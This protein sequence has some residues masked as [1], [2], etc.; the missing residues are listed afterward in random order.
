M[1]NSNLTVDVVENATDFAAMR[2]EWTE[3]LGASHSDCL[4]LTWEWLHTWWTHFGKHRRLFL[5][6]V[7][8]GS[9]LVAIAPLTSRR[10][11]VGPLAVPILEFA[12]TGTIGS[13][14]L[15]VIVRRTCETEALATLTAFLFEKA[16]TLRLPRISKSSGLATSLGNALAGRGWECATVPTEV[17]PFI[18]LSSRSWDDYLRSIGPSHRYNFKR[19][20]RNLMRDYDVR[21]QYAQSDEERR[22]G[23]RH[24]VNLHLQR[25]NPRGGSDA[26]DSAGLV[27][28]H[29]DL[30]RAARDRGWLRLMVI[31][32]DGQAAAAFY[33]F[34]YGDK[35]LFYQSGFDPAFGHSSVGLVMVGL[36][37]RDAIAEGATEYDML[38]GVEPYKFLWTKTVRQLVRLDLYPPGHVGRM[39]SNAARVTAGAK[40][41]AKRLL[42]AEPATPPLAEIQ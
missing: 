10:I 36:T 3:L 38:H 33:G 30:S 42:R 34:R 31:T 40:R 25:W 2:D 17:C 26:F 39:H 16:M 22:E 24:V 27:T 6:T 13:D 9:Q 12:G 1:T 41:F 8:S 5:V 21:I 28:F 7:R 14:Y 4:F 32:L 18:D 20:L 23:L 11:W 29:D 37:I 15:D 35:F 19:R